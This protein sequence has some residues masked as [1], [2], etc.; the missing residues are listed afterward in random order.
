MPS[1]RGITLQR[2]EVLNVD[3]YYLGAF[4][5]RVEATEAL[6]MDDRVFLYQRGPI[7]PYTNEA[8]DSFVTVCSPVDMED[9][10]A[11]EPDVRKTYPFFRKAEVELDFRTSAEAEEGWLAI[12]ERV[13][14]LVSS[15]N[16]L[17]D[18]TPTTSV[19]IGDDADSISDS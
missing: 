10:P 9:Y 2:Y 7:N 6:G 14:N 11:D 3:Y 4:R 8:T 16:T 12:V 5:L 1:P 19:R 18:L 17:E 13:S 15:L